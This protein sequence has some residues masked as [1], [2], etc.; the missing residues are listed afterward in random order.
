MMQYYMRNEGWSKGRAA[1]TYKDKFGV[2][3]RGLDDNRAMLPSPEVKKFIRN[4]LHAFL[5]RIGKR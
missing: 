5:K 1:N 4:K 3:P 2:W